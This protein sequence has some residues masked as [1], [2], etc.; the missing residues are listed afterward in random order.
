MI[1]SYN[2]KAKRKLEILIV[3]SLFYPISE[4]E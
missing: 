3:L 1:D 2:K 4:K